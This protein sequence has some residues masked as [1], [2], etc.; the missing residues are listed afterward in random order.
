MVL[1][2]PRLGVEPELQLPAYATATAMQDPSHVCDQHHSSRHCQILHLLGEARDAIMVS[3]FFFLFGHPAG[4]RV[5][6][7]QIPVTVATYAAATP[8]P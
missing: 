2:V 4:Y 6:R 7:N 3:F 5:P 8:D 1:E